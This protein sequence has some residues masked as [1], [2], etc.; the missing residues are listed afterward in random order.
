MGNKSRVMALQ[1]IYLFFFVTFIGSI[2]PE[3]GNI[4]AGKLNLYP[5]IFNIGF[6]I[7]GFTV[8]GLALYLRLGTC[9]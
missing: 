5:H 4:V 8:F 1:F 3:F 2:T 6:L 9:R 7:V